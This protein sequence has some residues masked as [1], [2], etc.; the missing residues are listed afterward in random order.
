MCVVDCQTMRCFLRKCRLENTH[1][2]PVPPPYHIGADVPMWA[3]A[4]FIWTARL[5]SY[6]DGDDGGGGGSQQRNSAGGPADVVFRPMVRWGRCSV[7][8]HR[9][10]TTIPQNRQFKCISRSMVKTATSQKGDRPKRR[11]TRTATSLSCNNQN[12]DMTSGGD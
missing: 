6:G 3:D 9:N 8:Q 4:C 5:S 12:G 7:Y 11:Q 10:N 2:P 1:R